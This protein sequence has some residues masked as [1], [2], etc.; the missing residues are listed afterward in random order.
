MGERAST[1]P[2][3]ITYS[4]PGAVPPVYV[5]GS[6]TQPEWQPLEL[7]YAL[8]ENKAEEAVD[9]TA[10]SFYRTF[11]L[12]EGSFQYKFRLGHEGDWWVCDGKAPIGRDSFQ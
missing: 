10:Y 6:F 7:E 2:V 11:H 12:P 8:D 4:S 9:A 1:Y 3:K 5:A